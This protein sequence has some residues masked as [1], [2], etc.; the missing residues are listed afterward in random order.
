M[1]TASLPDGWRDRLVPFQPAEALPARA[2]CVEKHDLVIS[3][4]AAMREKDK[5]FAEALLDAG[6]VDVRTLLARTEAL[7]C[8]PKV[9]RK[10]LRE[11][12]EAAAGRCRPAS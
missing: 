7:S 6:L 1:T 9:I 2:V 4:L 3:K 8:V 11:W 10:R 12:I 5:E